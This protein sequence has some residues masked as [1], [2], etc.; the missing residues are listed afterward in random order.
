M[1]NWE[2]GEEGGLG[3]AALQGLT[4]LLAARV[5]DAARPNTKKRGVSYVKELSHITTV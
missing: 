3:R 5:L 2:G 4:A 1:L